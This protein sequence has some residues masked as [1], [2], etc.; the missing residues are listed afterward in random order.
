MP[1]MILTSYLFFD[2]FDKQF[3][4]DIAA[5]LMTLSVVLLSVITSALFS[6]IDDYA[7]AL[8]KLTGEKASRFYCALR[9]NSPT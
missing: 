4:Y 1:L 7:V 6:F 2:L 5:L 9:A 3:G 8:S